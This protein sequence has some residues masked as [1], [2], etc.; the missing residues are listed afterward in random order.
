MDRKA[1]SV[2]L[3][4]GWSRASVRFDEENLV[5]CAGLVPVMALAERAGLSD[6]VADKV[7][8]T[9]EPIP[10]TGANP[11]GKITSIVAGMA[12]G[13]DSI[14]DLD[15]IRHG[16]MKR[17]F[18]GVYAPSTLGSFLRAFTHGHVLQLVAVLRAMV[19]TLAHRT[20]VLTGAHR[21]QST[22]LCG[23]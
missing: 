11:A 16:G 23:Y 10:S 18:V 7:K 22:D 14:D 13:A 5:S 15:V 19:V 6:L 21:C 8:I 3:L 17:L 1:L 9:G 2:R 12:A 20:P 4:H